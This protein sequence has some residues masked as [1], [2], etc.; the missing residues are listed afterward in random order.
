MIVFHNPGNESEFYIKRIIGL[1]G[2]EVVIDGGE[3]KIDGV[4]LNEAYLRTYGPVVGERVFDLGEDEYFMM[5]DNRGNSSD[6]RSWG[7]LK[8]DEVIGT[9]R[10]RFWP[11]SKLEKFR[12]AM[13]YTFS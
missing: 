7:P 6:S 4:T 5:G 12:R 9:V 8:R 2:E 1:P 10:L 3:V 13:S 11:P